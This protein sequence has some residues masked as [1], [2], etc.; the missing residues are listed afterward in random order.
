MSGKVKAP[1][2]PYCGNRSV[3]ID[4]AEVYSRSY[5]PIWICRPCHAWVGCHKGTKKPL[6]RL[7]DAELR[8]AKKAAHAAFDPL[9]KDTGL[10][11]EGYRWL[12]MRMGL[13]RDECHIGMFDVDQCNAVVALCR[14]YAARKSAV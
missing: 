1:I 5:G 8:E 13:G 14:E 6:G 12:A 4:S 10:R 9:F 3:C 7:A 2:C 11:N